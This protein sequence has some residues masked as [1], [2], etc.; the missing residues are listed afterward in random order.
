MSDNWIKV[1]PDDPYVVPHINRQQRALAH[2]KKL[3]PDAY[4]VRTDVFE[5][6]QFFGCGPENLVRIGCP[7]CDKDI[8][9]TWWLA[10][11]EKDDVGGYQLEEYSMPCCREKFTLDDLDY[12]GAQAFGR[13]VLEVWNPGID[14]RDEDLK[15]LENILG[16]ELR[17]VYVH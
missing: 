15:E 9:V 12:E 13:F 8:P 10:C 3:F 7:S 2:F 4:E 14:L 1:I 17:V 5:T 6:I 16:T 11:I